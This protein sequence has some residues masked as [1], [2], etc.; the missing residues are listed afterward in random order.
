M[1]VARPDLC[2]KEPPRLSLDEVEVFT[3]DGAYDFAS[4]VSKEGTLRSAG[5]LSRTKLA[6]KPALTVFQLLSNPKMYGGEPMR[7]FIPR[8]GLRFS[9]KEA[10]AEIL[11][12]LECFWIYFFYGAERVVASLS[13]GGRR[14][15]EG[16]FLDVTKPA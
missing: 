14:P 9:G 12:C 10:E 13:E 4:P 15:L 1:S 11:I 3:L 7:C 16:F 2:L 8:H 6:P 5:I